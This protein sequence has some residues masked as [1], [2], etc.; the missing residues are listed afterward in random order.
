MLG[1]KT[2]WCFTI[3]QRTPH[4]ENES[5]QQQ[6][7]TERY[8]GYGREGGSDQQRFRSRQDR[9]HHSEIGREA[10]RESD[11]KAEGVGKCGH[12]GGDGKKNGG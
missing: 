12:Q 11:R 3:V 5:H 7:Q 10:C 9:A 6:Q 1:S 4:R 2:L 8:P